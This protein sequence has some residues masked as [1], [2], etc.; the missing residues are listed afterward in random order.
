M[1]IKRPFRK[2]APFWDRYDSRLALVLIVFLLTGIVSTQESICRAG[3]CLPVPDFL[4]LRGVTAAFT[5]FAVM[6]AAYRHRHQQ[7]KVRPSVRED[8]DNLDDA[9]TPDFGLR[10]FGPGP[11]LYVQAVATLEREDEEGF[12]EERLTGHQIHDTPIHLREGEFLSLLN[13]VDENW[14]ADMRAEYEICEYSGSCDAEDPLYVNLY[15]TYVSQSGAREPPHITDDRED[16]NL[17]ND[18]DLKDSDSQARRIELCRIDE[19]C[20]TES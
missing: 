6:L 4:S 15:Y 17:L 13:E 19:H 1:G 16:E 5:A 7:D 18:G 10:N 20:P 8:F 11:A 9:G 12:I 2:W 3:Y 14:L